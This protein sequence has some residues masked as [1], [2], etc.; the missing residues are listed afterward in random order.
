MPKRSKKYIPRARRYNIFREM[1]KAN[2]GGLLNDVTE[3][4][5]RD[6]FETYD[7][8]AQ[9]FG[10]N[11]ATLLRW[12]HSGHWPVMALR[13]LLII[14]R[15]YLPTTGDWAG[16]KIT[17]LRGTNPKKP[18]QHLLYI[19]GF[20]EGFSPEDVRWY[21]M[22]KDHYNMLLEKEKQEEKARLEAEEK[23][24]HFTVINGSKQSN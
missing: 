9:F 4:M 10:V 12:R 22:L 6:L 24:E 13:L 5:L 16:C 18:P 3:M 17:K 1:V 8:A 19:P 11:P 15:G 2:Y 7:E 23:R 20:R 14:H 21:I